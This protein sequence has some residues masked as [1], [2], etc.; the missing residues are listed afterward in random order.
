MAARDRQ[1]LETATFARTIPIPTIGVGTTEFDIPPDRVKA[2]YESGYDAAMTFL[3]G[4][5]FEAYIDQFRRGKEPVRRTEL[6]RST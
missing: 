5:D 4:W 3:D 1:Y 2:L 6:V